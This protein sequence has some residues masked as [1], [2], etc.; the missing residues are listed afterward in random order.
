MPHGFCTTTPVDKYPGARSG[1]A[2]PDFR[3]YN[4]EVLQMALGNYYIPL[5]FFG[6]YF[7][8]FNTVFRQL[9]QK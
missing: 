1:P 7:E 9:I 3:N 4:G 2:V 5:Q 8:L 6:R